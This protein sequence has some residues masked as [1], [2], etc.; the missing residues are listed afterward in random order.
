VSAP[1]VQQPPPA[2]FQ[3]LVNKGARADL[4]ERDGSCQIRGWDER[5]E[6]INSGINPLAENFRTLRTRILHPVAGPPPRSLLITSASPAE[7]K[8]FV[9]ANLGIAIAQGVEQYALMVDCD[10]RRPALGQLF[11]LP[12]DRGLVDHLAN[13]ED[14]AN[15]ILKTGV[16]KLSLI[17]G[18]TP[19]DN[20]SE[21]LD[22]E[23]MVALVD[24][25]V[26][27]YQ[28]RLILLDSP[29]LQAASETAVLARHVDGVV[30]VAR[31]GGGRKEH[32]KA[33]VDTIGREKIVGVVF[34]GVRTTAL[35]TKIFGYTDYQSNYYRRQ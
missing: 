3:V 27:R 22:S 32:I 17:P 35:D 11:G 12:N 7:G 15:L 1:P 34:N 21:L 26:A 14:L 25:L 10:L 31:W 4:R 29:P 18:G 8:S 30:L 28:D 33:L 16:Y 6:G 23:R 13:G 5:L 20:P 9:C 2:T 19:P 24:E